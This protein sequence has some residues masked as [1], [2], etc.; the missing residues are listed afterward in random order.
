MTNSFAIEWPSQL[1][2]VAVKVKP[3]RRR[4][5]SRLRR[6]IPERCR[7]GEP[8]QMLANHAI[9]VLGPACTG[10]PRAPPP[11]WTVAGILD[12]LA[13]KI[14]NEWSHAMTWCRAA[15][16]ET[17]PAVCV[18]LRDI[19]LRRRGSAPSP[20]PSPRHCRQ[21]SRLMAKL[22]LGV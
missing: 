2:R 6:A 9:D 17:L 22:S 20:R 4:T 7:C 1:T 3:T 19:F 21:Q 15:A 11:A 8:R 5:A 16:L 13:A 12:S 14:E 10:D 18:A